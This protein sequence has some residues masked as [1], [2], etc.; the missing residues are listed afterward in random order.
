MD[1]SAF[2]MRSI[3]IGIDVGKQGGIA[4]IDDQGY[5]LELERM[6]VIGKS[7]KVYDHQAIIDLIT[8]Y[9]HKDTIVTVGIE[10][11]GMI[12]KISKS[13]N[14]SMMHGKGL[15][16]G[17]C[18]TLKVKTVLVHAKT[19]QKTMFEYGNKQ[20]VTY[21]KDGERKKKLDTK[22]TARI[23]AMRLYPE[24]DFLATSRSTKPHEGMI[25]ALLIAE[26]LRLTR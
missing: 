5:V 6:P 11:V 7:K 19:W 16:E 8:T 18:Y 26:H 15:L 22:A 2:L 20:Y 25:D 21:I 10:D 14:C 9:I 23:V 1:K 3:F 17:I 24:R 12:H 4:A 13:A